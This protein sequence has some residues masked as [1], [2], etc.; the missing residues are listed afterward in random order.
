[1]K[2]LISAG[3]VCAV[4][5][6]LVAVPGALGVKSPKL[7]SGTVSV[8]VSPLPLSDTTTSVSVS[9]NLASNSSCRKD[10]TLHFS[11]VTN[12]VPGAEVGSAV[13]RSNGDFSAIL[14]RPT[15]TSTTTS[16]VSLRTTVD[17]VTR[18]VGSKKK[19]KKAKKG[20]QF[21]CL[22]ISADVPVALTP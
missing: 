9:G 3:V 10:R 7:V 5:V 6:G 4:A 14:S 12:G 17:Q 22:T 20:R 18:K 1:M 2:K 16:S 8:G 11:W 13:T 19:G 21:E 15:D